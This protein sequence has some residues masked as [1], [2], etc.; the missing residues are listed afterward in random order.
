MYLTFL[1]HFNVLLFLHIF[2]SQLPSISKKHVWL[3][4]LWTERVYFLFDDRCSMSGDL[5]E[6]GLSSN[7]EDGNSS[8]SSKEDMSN[9]KDKEVLHL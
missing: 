4:V 9:S 1:H 2:V 3:L 7:E 5:S 6:D 8:D